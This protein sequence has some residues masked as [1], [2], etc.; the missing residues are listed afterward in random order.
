MAADTSDI[1]QGTLD[2]V[3]VKTLDTMGPASLPVSR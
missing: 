3:V 2:V 1:L